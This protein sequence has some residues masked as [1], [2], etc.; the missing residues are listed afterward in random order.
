M[1]LF[2]LVWLS[3]FLYSILYLPKSP[4]S[5]NSAMANLHELGYLIIHIFRVLGYWIYGLLIQFDHRFSYRFFSAATK[6]KVDHEY[7]IINTFKGSSGLF[8][9]LG[10]AVTLS[11]P[12]S[13]QS[14]TYSRPRAERIDT[15]SAAFIRI[16]HYV[17]A[18]PT[19]DRINVSLGDEVQYF[20]HRGIS[21][22]SKPDHFLFGG[23][24]RIADLPDPREKLG[25]DPLLC[26][27]AA[28]A[29]EQIA[30]VYN[31]RIKTGIRRD[32][33]SIRVGKPCWDKS[34]AKPQLEQPPA[35]CASVGPAP[36]QTVVDREVDEDTARSMLESKAIDLSPSF[37][38]RNLLASSQFM[39]FT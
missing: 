14:E 15:P 12:P 4:S 13:T 24:W 11:F 23:N 16:V 3:I 1:S 6:A 26:A 37:K 19:D 20:W 7:E 36:E 38:K 28:S 22:S 18:L 31:W 33:R 2:E 29:A 35:W 5:I 9:R 34:L 39:Y 30:E 8:D 32:L 10:R 21:D 27:I 17:R 25:Y